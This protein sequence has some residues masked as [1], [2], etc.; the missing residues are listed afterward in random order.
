MDDVIK[1]ESWSI[2]VKTTDGRRIN[3]LDLDIDLPETAVQLIDETLQSEF[4]CTMIDQYGNKIPSDLVALTRGI[5]RFNEEELKII[6]NARWYEVYHSYGRGL[7]V[8]FSEIQGIIDNPDSLGGV[9]IKILLIDDV[10][11]RWSIEDG[12]YHA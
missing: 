2:F 7:A 3:V 4:S 9:P 12:F 11:K 5:D 10:L 1:I 8:S 6:C